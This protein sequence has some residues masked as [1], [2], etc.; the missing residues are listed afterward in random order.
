MNHNTRI[1]LIMLA[2]ATTGAGTALGDH[3]DVTHK[4]Q[5]TVKHRPNFVWQGRWDART[6]A[7]ASDN[8]ETALPDNDVGSFIFPPANNGMIFSKAAVTDCLG[9]ANAS[10]NANG[11]GGGSH[12]IWGDAL[13][14]GP[15]P[16]NATARS[17]S[18][19]HK[20]TGT[21]DGIGG[22]RYGGWARV[23][24]LKK[25][26]KARDPL[27]FEVTN[28]LTG[29]TMES[30]PWDFYAEIS[31]GGTILWD[32]DKVAVIDTGPSYVGVVDYSIGGPYFTTPGGSLHLVLSGG[33]VTES[34]DEG[35]FD[36][37]LPA[38]G[39]TVDPT[40]SFPLPNEWDLDFDFGPENPLGYDFNVTVGADAL[41]D[42]PSPGAWLFSLAGLGAALRRRR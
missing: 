40:F 9:I 26:A 11:A 24:S 5:F 4:F 25:H 14:T 18:V 16:I 6:D 41:A 2:L 27:H 12:R 17:E 38:I 36:G 8:D 10:A 22:V 37:L 42:V 33:L 19:I 1:L 32:D 34:V 13:V 3:Y 31:G 29:D 7:T 23:D 35:I 28:L 20:R 30:T 39:T 15:R 21:S